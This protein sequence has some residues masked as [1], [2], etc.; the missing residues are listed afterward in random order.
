MSQNLTGKAKSC[1]AIV[2][3]VLNPAGLSC[4]GAYRIHWHYWY[5]CQISLMDLGSPCRRKPEWLLQRTKSPP[6]SIA[7]LSR[8]LHIFL[9]GIFAFSCAYQW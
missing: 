2:L 9:Y 8:C 5:L 1:T 7:S 6:A 4:P 3:V